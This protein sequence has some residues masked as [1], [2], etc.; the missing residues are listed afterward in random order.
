MKRGILLTHLFV[1]QN[2][3]YKL[4]IMDLCVEH[5]RKHNP[6][7][8]IVITGHGLRPRSSTI[9]MCD[10][11]YWEPDIIR[12]EINVG[13]PKLVNIGFDILHNTGISKICK[14][15]IDAI[16]PIPNITKFCD[17]IIT[18]ENTKKLITTT[19]NCDYHMGDLFTYG[20]AN[21]LKDCWRYDTWYPTNTGLR[22]LGKNFVRAVG[23]TIPE[24]WDQNAKLLDDKTWHDLLVEHTSYRNPETLKWIDFRRHWQSIMGMPDYRNRVLNNDFDY[25]NF[26]WIDW[27]QQ[28]DAYP[29]TEETFYGS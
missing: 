24:Q 21:F 11:I 16:H 15:R 9:D 6:D 4:D 19:N 29:Y 13:H 22:S 27:P 25:S 8:Y 7:D 26:I 18:K 17:D 23:G 12:E 14:A 10:N 28:P 20:D 3:D 1:E 2:E 5:F